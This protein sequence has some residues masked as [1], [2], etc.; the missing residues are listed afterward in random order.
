[1]THRE[2]ELA[3]DRPAAAQTLEPRIAPA[4]YP[5]HM[6]REP[7]PYRPGV[8]RVKVDRWLDKSFH[9]REVQRIWKKV[10]Q[11]ACREEEIP[12]AGDFYVY[13]IA[14]MSFIIMRTQTGEIKAFWNA[15]PHRGRKLKEHDGCG[16]SE[17][18]CMFHGWAWQLDGSVKNIACK[19][20][21]PEVTQDETRLYEA[22]LGTWGGFVFI[23]PDLDCEPL[24]DFLGTLPDHF[25]GAGHD[26]AK[27][28][29]QVHVACVVDCNW[30]VAMEAFTEA[31]HVQTTHPQLA[32]LSGGQL[33]VAGRWDD[34]GNYMRTA[35]NTPD[36]KQK[37]L[38]GHFNYADNEQD[39]LD[40]FFGRNLAEPPDVAAHPGE[41]SSKITVAHIRQFFRTVI[42]DK[43]DEYHD[44][45]LAGGAM[46]HVFP[47]FHPWGNFSRLLYRFRPYKG[48]PGRSII[49]VML[50]APWPE[51]RP[52]PPPAEVHWLEPDQTTADAPELGS[53]ARVFLQD[54]ANMPAVQAGLKII[55]E[56]QGYIIL[57]SH[58][59]APV[60]HLH[61]L[62]DKWMGLEDGE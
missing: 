47:N 19:W 18:R 55:R 2:N 62:Y 4:P 60:R 58:N 37:A 38:P 40:S 3:A 32:F 50:M 8:K 31:W 5:E 12:E 1:M 29:K 59:E 14:E 17:L 13:D 20:D 33:M 56:R 28:W 34:F 52:R 48:D 24:A 23:N 45:E 53:L 30:K 41:S 35:P 46:F 27:R 57:S 10:W 54:L 36:D 6:K 51:D 11:F 39:A 25:E 15:C 16:V 42:G 43:I 61:D 7:P 9:D 44:V 22:K 26:M 21:F 49:D